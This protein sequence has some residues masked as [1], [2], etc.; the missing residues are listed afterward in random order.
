MILPVHNGER[1][2]AAKL[3]SL[4]ALAYPPELMEILVASR[5]VH[6]R[7][8]WRWRSA[9]SRRCPSSSC[10]ICRT[11]G[12]PSALNAAMARASGEILFFTDVRQ[13]LDPASLC[14]LVDCFAD[15]EVGVASGEL[16]IRD[17]ATLEEASVG[18]YW[19]YEKW[20]R[21]QLSRLDSVPGAT[22]CIYAMRRSLAAPLPAGHAERRHVPPAGRLLPRLPGDSGRVS[23]LAFDYPT[24]LASEFRRKV[25]TLAGVY[26][27]VGFY[28]GAAGSA[29]SHVDSLR[30]A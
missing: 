25:R 16:V 1:F 14:N 28:P 26:Q 30:L 22:G 11:A 8:A 27:I 13:H 7:D 3:E 24:A 12:R 19:K 29:Q 2:I 17:S 6:R 10:S 21:K 5:W 23:A 9:F 20:I 4:R 15:P 18:L